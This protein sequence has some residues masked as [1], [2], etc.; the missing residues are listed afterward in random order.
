MNFLDEV[1]SPKQR[2]QLADENMW[3]N[4][5]DEWLDYNS[6]EESVSED[7]N[8]PNTKANGDKLLEADL[9]EKLD[10]KE[11]MDGQGEDPLYS[12]QSDD[13]DQKWVEK[14]LTKYLGD[15]RQSDAVLN[16][17]CC[18]ALLT[19]DCQRHD[20][21]LTQYR[22]MFVRNCKLSAEEIKY[23]KKPSADEKPFQF[24]DQIMV[25]DED[26]YDQDLFSL[27]SCAVCDTEIGAVDKD[28]VYHF[29]N[30]LPSE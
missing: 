13:K 2:L 26:K 27:V 18:F 14:N 3:I 20:I 4:E 25:E 17:P 10:P 11:M 9:K 12:E 21:Y 7:E 1:L 8:E 29:Y 30:V 23:K 24:V 22:A 28:E 19:M 5:S 6:G 15:G 16:C